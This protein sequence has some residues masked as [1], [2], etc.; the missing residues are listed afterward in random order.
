MSALYRGALYVP[1]R[2]PLWQQARTLTDGRTFVQGDLV[3]LRPKLD[4]SAAPVLTKPL[5]PGRTIN[6]HNGLLRHDDVLGKR[7][8]DVVKTTTAEYRLHEVRLEEFVR[9]SRRLVTPIYPA[10]ANLIVSLFD[11]HPE[12]YDSTTTDEDEKA[13]LEILEA[14]TG[15]GALTL[16]LSRAI[17]AANPPR[18]RNDV[19]KGEEDLQL[20]EEKWRSSRGAV[21]HSIDSSLKFSTHAETTVKAFKHGMYYHNI[22]FHVTDVGAWTRKQLIARG[23]QPF[24]SHAFLDLP[25]V[26]AQL[27]DVA[28]ALEVD[29]TLIVFVPSITQ[30][31]D[32]VQQ[33]RRKGTALELDTVLELAV[34]GGSG[35]REWNVK[36]V[37]PRAKQQAVADD[38]QSIEKDASMANTNALKD[39]LAKH[40]TTNG[41]ADEL[42]TNEDWSVICRPKVGDRIVGGGFLGVWKKQRDMRQPRES[43][44]AEVVRDHS[45]GQPSAA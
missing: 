33:I 24:L 42:L 20:A 40:A 23:E 27:D 39:E 34:N 21:I 9:L 11:L 29:G 4:R 37:K 7:V 22:D 18:P 19:V 38:H 30:I 2:Y 3:L 31:L 5:Q 17:H 45:A 15:H 14:G 6:N 12:A 8:R 41:Q 44:E 1:G 35:G 26:D 13:K 10:D 43:S 16:Y 32:C 36:L 25:G 28:R